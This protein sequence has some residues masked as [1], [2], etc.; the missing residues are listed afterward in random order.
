M[1]DITDLQ[2]GSSQTRPLDSDI[3]NEKEQTNLSSTVL[4]ELFFF[5]N[6]WHIG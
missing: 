6:L 5:T 3:S 2:N 1:Y 4:G